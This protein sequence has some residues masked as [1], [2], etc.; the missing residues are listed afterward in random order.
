M[1][2]YTEHVRVMRTHVL[3]GDL[4][5]LLL[6]TFATVALRWRQEITSSHFG[7]IPVLLIIALPIFW[8]IGL[9]T[10]DAWEFIALENPR[11]LVSKA[12]S[13]SWRTA[14]AFAFT[15][16]AVHNAISRLW[17]FSQLFFTTLAI[18]LFR[19]L[20]WGI[21]SRKSSKVVQ[22]YVLITNSNF[23]PIEVPRRRGAG[24]SVVFPM[25]L[26][27][28]D[29]ER[30]IFLENLER[31]I[32]EHSIDALVVGQNAISDPETLYRLSQMYSHGLG[33]I[34]LNDPS[35]MVMSRFKPMPN[36]SWIRL[37]EPSLADSGYFI[38]RTMD[39][40]GSSF[41]LLLTSPLWIL[42]AIAVKITSPGPILYKAERVGQGGK[43][44]QFPKF[45]SM[46]EG[47]DLSRRELLGMPDAQMAERYKRDPRIT[48]VGRFLRRWSIDELPQLWSVLKGDMSLVGPRPIL[49]EEL[50]Q[51][52][53]NHTYRFV[54][55]P[56]LTG[57]WQTSGRKEVDWSD[58]MAQDVYYIDTWSPIQ[59]LILIAR[60]VLSIL[61]GRGA[62]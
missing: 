4:L 14:L 59:D 20:I 21:S 8:I 46:Y 35:S 5:A 7:Q 33:G 55:K 19:L 11:I 60:T 13:A 54:A 31:Y 15:A 52:E 16:F 3:T 18:A 2:S 22:K 37:G 28:T 58:R 1:S 34:I 43:H 30:E 10:V 38:K 36:P 56:G 17:F 24:E 40:I 62:Y 45:R 51:I 47:S 44:F 23:D 57:V 25:L 48:P 32:Q 6:V 12:V 49:P 53:I 42:A 27:S 61:S 9:S 50:D 26:D 41:L 39:L 29:A